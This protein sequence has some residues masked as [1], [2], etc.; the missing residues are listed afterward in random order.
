MH[1][2]VVQNPLIRENLDVICEAIKDL[3]LKP[4]RNASLEFFC[5]LKTGQI[6]YTPSMIPPH[7]MAVLIIDLDMDKK[8]IS[9]RTKESEKLEAKAVAHLK[10]MAEILKK[11]FLKIDKLGQLNQIHWQKPFEKEGEDS[12]LKQT[13]HD[14]DRDGAE[15]LLLKQKKGTF[16]FRKDH[17]AITLQEILKRGH[18]KTVQCY[19]LSY[20]DDEGIVRDRT[21]VFANQ[22]WTFYD[23]DPTLSGPSFPTVSLLVNSMGSL[24]KYPMFSRNAVLG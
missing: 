1:S 7:E 4:E 18:K 17:Y 2:E 16:L 22:K 15:R 6:L 21:V 10:E 13:W 14:I 24:T 9:W 20:L 19:T 11:T 5:D 8:T 3:D 12:I 23:D